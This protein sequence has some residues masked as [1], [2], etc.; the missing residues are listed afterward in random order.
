MNEINEL[1]EGIK[2]VRKTISATF[3]KEHKHCKEC[4]KVIMR[5]K[6]MIGYYYE[7]TNYYKL[8]VCEN[9]VIKKGIKEVK[10]RSKKK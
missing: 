9:C 5:Y 2:E 6:H 1:R 7:E 10:K 3:V 4:G 8:A